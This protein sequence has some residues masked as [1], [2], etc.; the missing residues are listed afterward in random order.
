ME[1]GNDRLSAIG[2]LNHFIVFETPTSHITAHPES[3]PSEKT[4]KKA[5][6]E[7]LR[8]TIQN[9]F[10][11]GPVTVST[12]GKCSP[13]MDNCE[14]YAILHYR[15]QSLKIDSIGSEFSPV[16]KDQVSWVDNRY[17]TITFIRGASSGGIA[18]AAFDYG[19]IFYLGEFNT[20]E[21]GYLIKTYVLDGAMS[22]SALDPRWDLYFRYKNN[23]AV[24]DIKKT[25]LVAKDDYEKDKKG[26]MA[27]L[28]TP[29]K[30]DLSSDEIALWSEINVNAPLLRTLALARY[31]GWQNDYMKILKVAK[32]NP[33]KLVT[34][35]TLHKISAELSQIEQPQAE[36]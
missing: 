33:D 1:L 23:Q 22:A 12:I 29:K 7:V 28:S 16:S 14:S 17:I 24:L 25:C 11:A 21:D 31:C 36:Q 15:D 27:V 34:W 26:L 6:K 8:D 30:L 10:K 32:S 13:I 9:D 3:N 4:Q 35:E 18:V 20:I 5:S 19:K 2:I